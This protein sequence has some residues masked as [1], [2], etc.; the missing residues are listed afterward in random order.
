M[1]GR[2]HLEQLMLACVLISTHACM[3]INFD[4]CLHVYQFVCEV[5]ELV[6]AETVKADTPG[7][8]NP[9]TSPPSPSA[10]SSLP[11]SLPPLSSPLVPESLQLSW[12][13]RGISSLN[14]QSAK[15][16]S[17]CLFLGNESRVVSTL[18]ALPS[19]SATETPTIWSHDTYVATA[20][21]PRLPPFILSNCTIY[22]NNPIKS[23]MH[24]CGC[25][26]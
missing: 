23:H 19:R 12:V 18:P 20:L 26:W 11:L 14:T 2:K 15:K 16:H 13:H 9:F 21:I 17:I 1:V 8:T 3:C 25:V 5:A 4:S 24:N 6:E 10:A 22:A 7:F